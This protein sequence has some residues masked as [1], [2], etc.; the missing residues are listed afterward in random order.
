MQ[1]DLEALGDFTFRVEEK[2]TKKEASGSDVC[3]LWMC[4]LALAAP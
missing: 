1:W 3:V 2:F 4:P